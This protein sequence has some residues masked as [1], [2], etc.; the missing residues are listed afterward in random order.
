VW[1]GFALGGLL[2]VGCAG[3]HS[4]DGL[5]A[6][7]NLEQ[8][9][10]VFRL[11]DAQRADQARAFELGLA[12][13]TL[14]ADRA[15]I[16]AGV[17]ACPGSTREPLA[18]SPGD[19]VRDTVR[20][21][22]QGDPVRQASLAQVALA[23]WRLRRARATGDAGMCDEARAA[24]TSTVSVPS[25]FE[26]FEQLGVA[27]V[28]RDAQLSSAAN[29]SP[30]DNPLVDLSLYASG[31]A[32]DVTAKAPLPQ[33][34]AAVYGGSVNASSMNGSLLNGRAPELV[35]DELAP[36]YPEWEPDALLAALSSS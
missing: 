9:A 17:T 12:D 10:A 6:Q 20:I 23:D 31:W 25:R 32:D 8:E 16:A 7:Q 18:V 11:S 36:A 3:P 19:R 35:V 26:N 14:A 13:E 33:Y 28:T 21:R 29:L 27:T 2:L 1:I 34:L 15:R 5:W 24:L 22:V 30:N 4:S